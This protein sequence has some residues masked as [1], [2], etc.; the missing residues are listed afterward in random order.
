M[1]TSVKVLAMSLGLGVACNT[2]ADGLA[3]CDSGPESGWKSTEEL[4]AQLEAKGWKVRRIKVDGGC[5]ETYALDD[6]GDR[7]E[8]YFDPRNLEQVPTKPRGER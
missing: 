2:F 4:T 3:T 7:V 8:V 1:K 5:Y 6:K